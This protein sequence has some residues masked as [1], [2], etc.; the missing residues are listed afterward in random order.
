MKRPRIV[1]WNILFIVLGL[2]VVLNVILA[3][4]VA[5][6]I[7]RVVLV[8]GT[9]DV[10]R[11]LPYTF[12]DYLLFASLA[13]TFVAFLITILVMLFKSFTDLLYAFVVSLTTAF[14]KAL[15]IGSLMRKRISKR[16]T[17]DVCSDSH[18]GEASV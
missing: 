9:T 15:N 11:P 7:D 13:V 17:G 6:R 10:Y 3:I 8:P 12:G 4:T 5:L 16:D 1:S 2:I 18:S 14:A